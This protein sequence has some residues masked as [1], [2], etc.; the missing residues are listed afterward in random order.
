MSITEKTRT[1]A[2]CPYGDGYGITLREYYAGLAMQ[3]LLANPAVIAPDS[4]QGWNYVNC[5]MDTLS[6]VAANQ[7]DALLAALDKDKPRE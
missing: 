4:Q 6:I 5:T 3:G 2:P 7:A 1:F